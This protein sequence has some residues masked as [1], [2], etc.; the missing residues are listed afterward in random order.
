M[1][2]LL[3]ALF[4]MSLMW[5]L[6]VSFLSKVMPRNFA[7]LTKGMGALL[8]SR[9]VHLSVFVHPK[10]MHLDF[11]FEI[12]RLSD[13]RFVCSEFSVFCS[14]PMALFECLCDVQMAMSSAYSAILER[15]GIFFSLELIARTKRMGL[16]T[17]PCISPDD[18]N[19]VVERCSKCFTWNDR[20]VR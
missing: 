5:C 6:N 13:C 15:G 16:R 18:G 10:M 17:D 3:F 19:L 4:V 7:V 14:V 8:H 12:L 1:F 20:E 9:G 11:G 2:T